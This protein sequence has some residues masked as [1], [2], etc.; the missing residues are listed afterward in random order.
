MQIECTQCKCN[1]DAF[2][3][4][5]EISMLSTETRGE[6]SK[7]KSQVVHPYQP[8]KIMEK[9]PEGLPPL[10]EG[11]TTIDID[12]NISVDKAYEL[13]FTESDFYKNWLFVSF[14]FHS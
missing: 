5:T 6:K 9:P 12:L 14:F 13:F 1:A 10:P 8:N 7:R 4:Q 11:K 2:S 3:L